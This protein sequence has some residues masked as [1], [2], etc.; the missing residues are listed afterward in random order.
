MSRN[1]TTHITM[2]S[3]PGLS[4]NKTGTETE[5]AQKDQKFGRGDQNGGPQGGPGV[6][7]HGLGGPRNG[8]Q[9]G[10]GGL[11]ERG[12][13]GRGHGHGP[14]HSSSISKEPT[15]APATVG[16]TG[17]PV[18][19]EPSQTTEGPVSEATVE[20]QTTST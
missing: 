20:A 12:P 2:M 7:P 13:G 4:R 18:T 19:A 14:H 8:P 1:V 5:Q 10:R 16:P 11:G 6:G 9:G 15:G 17:N 3:R